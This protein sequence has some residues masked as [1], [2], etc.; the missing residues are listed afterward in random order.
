[1]LATEPDLVVVLGPSTNVD[2]VSVPLFEEANITMSVTTGNPLYNTNDD[3]VFFWRLV[4][5]DDVAG[6]AL[7]I[8]GDEMGY[9][10]AASVFG[11]DDASQG[12]VKTFKIAWASLGNDLVVDLTIAPDSVSYSTEALQIANSGADSMYMETSPDTA[13][14]LLAELQKLDALLPILGTGVTF[15]PEWLNAVEAAIGL[16]ALEEYYIG[17]VQ[18]Y[19]PP[20]AE[21]GP[22]WDVYNQRIIENIGN[23]SV[24]E[25]WGDWSWSGDAWSMGA[26][27]GSVS[28]ALAMV[29]S[30]SL[31]PA[32]FNSAIR[33]VT[34]PGDGKTV[35]YTFG[36]GKAALEAGES[37]QYIGAGGEL[38]FDGWNNT[39]GPFEVRNRNGVQVLVITTE[40]LAAVVG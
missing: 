39:T 5:A 24:P 3:N 20:E 30:G 13:A 37:I 36:E 9:T 10:K 6:R 22:A 35:V 31:D 33:T 11:A 14:A 25:D 2:T 4:P 26:Y 1:L 16:E 34:E 8:A 32:V 29:A 23:V 27:D 19:Q 17:G 38:V 40:Q 15:L 21:R 28:A 7:A 18:G 12:A